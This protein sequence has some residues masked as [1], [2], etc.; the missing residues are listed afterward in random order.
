MSKKSYEIGSGNVFKDLAQAFNDAK[1][2]SVE[3][4]GQ[5]TPSRIDPSTIA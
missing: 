3:K 5:N 4:N 1:A 2:A